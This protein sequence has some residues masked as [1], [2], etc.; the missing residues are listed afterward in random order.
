[1]N[2]VKQAKEMAPDLHELYKD[3]HSHPELPMQEFRTSRKVVEFLEKNGIERIPLDTPTSVAAVIRGGK[4]GKTV[5]LRTELDALPITEESSCEFPSLNPGVMHACGH[6]VHLTCLIGAAKMLAEHKDKISGQIILLFQAAEENGCGARQMIEAGILTQKI[7][8]LFGLHTNTGIDAGKVAF[9]PGA[10]QASADVF[11]IVIQGSGGH[12]AF[13]HTA[14]DPV[15]IAGQMISQLHTVVSRNVDPMQTAVLSVCRMEAGT[16][17]NIIPEEAV[18]TGTYRAMAPEVRRLI[19]ERIQQI[20]SGIETSYQ[21]RCTVELPEGCPP[22]VNDTD[23]TRFATEAC[24]HV[25]GEENVVDLPPAMVG[26]DMAFFLEKVPGLLG[27]LGVR[28]EQ[29]GIIYGNH[30]PRFAVDEEC[31]RVG[32]AAMAQMA[33]EYLERNK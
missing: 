11:R 23:L 29:K 30:T 7:D 10:S 31:L 24:S 18:L 3:F 5:A 14:I 4:P 27:A 15:M 8:A 1:M 12:G 32:A 28:N 26:D 19:R 25:L 21:C 2:F 22:I 20:C 33:W 6:D 16:S 9:M 13:P 17:D